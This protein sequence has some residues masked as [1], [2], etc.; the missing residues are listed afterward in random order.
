M[1]SGLEPL[2]NA[3]SEGNLDKAQRLHSAGASLHLHATHDEG[4]TPLHCACFAGHLAI[5][6]WL[7][8]AGA[9]LDAIDNRAYRPLNVACMEGHLDIAQWL[10]SAGASLN[11]T[12]TKGQTPLHHACKTRPCLQKHLD[13]AQWLC[14]AGADATLKDHYGSTPAKLLKNPHQFDKQAV[15]S[16][17]ACLARREQAQGPLIYIIRSRVWAFKLTR[18]HLAA[19]CGTKAVRSRACG[20]PGG[21]AGSAGGWR[22]RERAD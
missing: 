6:Q 14:S 20:R 5:A 11:A 16:T 19:R 10:H 2:H 7:H 21:S 22:E 8:S 3:C 18:L 17:L 13:V 12:E 1:Q 4:F 15:R 9:S